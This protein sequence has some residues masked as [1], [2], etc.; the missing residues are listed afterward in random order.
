MGVVVVVDLGL[1]S[2]HHL[3]LHLV[4]VSVAVAALEVFAVA[5]EAVVVT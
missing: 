1:L 4:Q 2:A 5:S 3:L